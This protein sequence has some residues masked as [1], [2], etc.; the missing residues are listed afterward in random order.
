MSDADDLAQALC[1]QVD[2]D[3]WFPEQGQSA[4]P[5]KDI[6]ARCPIL[7]ACYAYTLVAQPRYGVW[8][9]LTERDRRKLQGRTRTATCAECGETFPVTSGI[10][11]PK[12]GHDECRAQARR[13]RDRNRPKQRKGAA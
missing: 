6:C 5:A 13:R 11:L 2:G 3:L 10:A 8:A 12:Y 4:Q 9:G 7:Q 1:A